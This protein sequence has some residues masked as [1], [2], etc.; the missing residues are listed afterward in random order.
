LVKLGVTLSKGNPGNSE[1]SCGRGRDVE[2]EK[3]LHRI[4]I[5]CK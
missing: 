5:H 4:F 1:L 3:F 2:N